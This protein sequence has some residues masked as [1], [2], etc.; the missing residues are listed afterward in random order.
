MLDPISVISGGISIV[1]DLWQFLSFARDVAG[2]DV[3]SAYFK[4]D[5]TRLEGSERIIVEK[6]EDE[7]DPNSWWFSVQDESE[8]V[9]VRYPVVQ[10]CAYELVGQVPGGAHPDA[11]YWRWVPPVPPGAI[12]GPNR[13]NLAVNFIVVGY[14]PKALV[15]YFS[16]SHGKHV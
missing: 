15:Q 12:A 5:G 13:Q 3:I 11:R 8:Y 9:Y 16:S 10:S 6:H 2:A 7:S 1:K 4:W 14:R